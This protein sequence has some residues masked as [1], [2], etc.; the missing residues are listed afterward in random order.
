MRS[1]SEFIIVKRV[2]FAHFGLRGGCR[3]S[4]ARRRVLLAGV[5]SKLKARDE[6]EQTQVQSEASKGRRRDEGSLRGLTITSPNGRDERKPAGS[7]PAI[8]CDSLKI[9]EGY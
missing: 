7:K 4:D 8:S 1:R 6:N 9:K 3:G 5:G 2:L